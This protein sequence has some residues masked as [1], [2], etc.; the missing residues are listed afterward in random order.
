MKPSF[1]AFLL[2]VPL[3]FAVQ[4]QAQDLAD[5]CGD[6]RINFNIKTEKKQPEPAPPA[7]GKAQIVLIETLNKCPGCGNPS[8]RFGMDGAWVGANKG[9]SYFTLD[10]APG[11]HALCVALQ[12]SGSGAIHR[13]GPVRLTAEAGNVYYFEATASLHLHKTKNENYQELPMVQAGQQSDPMQTRTLA[14]DAP[15]ELE[16]V[17]PDLDFAQLGGDAGKSRVMAAAHS[18]SQPKK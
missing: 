8:I 18:I 5:A 15:S 12:S 11:E 9:N 1:S 6:G 14:T 2:C 16:V 7:A 13:L 4:A 10:V 17:V 3:V